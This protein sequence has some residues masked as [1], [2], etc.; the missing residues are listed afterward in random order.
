MK[1]ERR[2][3]FEDLDCFGLGFAIKPKGSKARL[4]N[5]KRERLGG[6]LFYNLHRCTVSAVMDIY[7]TDIFG[8]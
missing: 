5:F 4:A 3:D 7:V 1:G 8:S 6:A 2:P